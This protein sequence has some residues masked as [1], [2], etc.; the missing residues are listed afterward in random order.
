MDYDTCDCIRWLC[1]ARMLAWMQP[2]GCLAPSNFSVSLN[3]LTNVKITTVYRRRQ[4]TTQ[5]TLLQY[6]S[7]LFKFFSSLVSNLAS[8]F[9]LSVFNLTGKTNNMHHYCITFDIHFSLCKVNLF[10]CCGRHLRL[11][12]MCGLFMLKIIIFKKFSA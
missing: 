10:Q 7:S 9:Y 2:H 6:K 1:G 8:F 5:N 4:N 12:D 3:N 11:I